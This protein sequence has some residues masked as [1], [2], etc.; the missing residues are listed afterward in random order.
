MNLKNFIR[1]T[2]NLKNFIRETRN[3]PL[4]CFMKEHGLQ[5]KAT[6]GSKIVE[7]ANKYK[8]KRF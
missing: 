8:V 7:I 1:E 3:S 6:K 4:D 5:N 2:T